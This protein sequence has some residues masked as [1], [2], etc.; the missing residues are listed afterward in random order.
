MNKFLLSLSLLITTSIFAKKV[1]F[2]VD[3][4]GQTI[5]AF[6]VH[7]AGNFQVAAGYPMDWDYAGTLLSQEGSTDVY[8]IVV[9][10]P[11]FKTY[12]F[13]FVNGD[14]GYESEYVPD[15]VRV[16]YNFN[17]NRW[18]YVDS[19]SNDT[20]FLGAIQFGLTSP[21]N[22]FTIRYKVD[23]SLVSL[24]GNGV[25]TSTN[26]Y[27]FSNTKNAMV[28]FTDNPMPNVYEVINYVDAGIYDF[29]F[30][31]GN[32]VAGK[33]SSV[34]GSCS[35]SG[36][37]YITVSKDTVF[38][39]VCFN[40]CVTCALT[41]IKESNI[42]NSNI[43]VYPNPAKNSI[44]VSSDKQEISKIEIFNMTGQKVIEYKNLSALQF[45]V[46]N[47]EL[48]AG[49]YMVKVYGATNLESQ[50]IKLIVE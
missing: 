30:V 28:T 4:T 11:A 35:N 3:M 22:K 48:S 50:N 40:S 41:G 6:G 14:Q 36:V 15:E 13:K 39:D 9:D 25:H 24:T 17:D 32:S 21:V 33:E 18:M 23:M 26:Y 12:E 29:N 42:S 1:K 19:L 20:S 38:P 37:R 49:I 5:S 10:I 43:V 7:V 31:N 44:H 45:T 2:A 16:G 34:P 46:N 47:P 27:A 8:S